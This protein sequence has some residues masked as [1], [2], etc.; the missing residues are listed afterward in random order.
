[1]DLARPRRYHP[2]HTSIYIDYYRHVIYRYILPVSNLPCKMLKI[3]L[4]VTFLTKLPINGVFNCSFF[5]YFTFRNCVLPLCDEGI[6]K[7][8]KRV[9]LH[10]T[11]TF[12][13]RT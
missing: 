6:F 9:F 5:P 10:E 2:D 13:F 8:L 11:A 7:I 1:M 3:G 12:R 4:F